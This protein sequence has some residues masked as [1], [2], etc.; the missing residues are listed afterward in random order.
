MEW[1]VALGIILA[2]LFVL[3][4]AVTASKRSSRGKGSA[5]G[6]LGIDLALTAALDPAK[7]AAIE[8]IQKKAEV[9]DEESETEGE[10]PR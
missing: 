7:A 9:G 10:L 3:P 2:A 8:T 4:W 5:G 1:L 6:A